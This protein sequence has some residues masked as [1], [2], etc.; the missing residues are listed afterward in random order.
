MSVYENY[1][2]LVE[3]D[4]LSF[5]YNDINL[6]EINS[7]SNSFKNPIKSTSFLFNNNSGFLFNPLYNSI[8][9]SATSNVFTNDLIVHGTL[10]A[11]S[12]PSNVLILD[13]DNKIN[14]SYLPSINNFIV[15]NTNSIAIGTSTPIAQIQLNDGNAYF[16][17]SRIG[18]GTF[19]SYY[20]HL[21]KVDTM[22]LQPAFVVSSNSK[23]II[24]IYSEL[25]TIVINND[26]SSLDTNAKLN[27]I[28]L[29][30]TSEIKTPFFST[31]N[32]S[33]IINNELFI[34]NINS[35]QSSIIINSNIDLILSN[36]SIGSLS[37]N[38][39][40]LNNS[41]KYLNNNSNL[42]LTSSNTFIN[43]LQTSTI[44]TS[45]INIINM[46]NLTSNPSAESV[47]D[48]KGKIRLFNDTENIIIKI[49]A[50]DTNI[51]LITKNNKLYSYSSNEISLISSNFF[52]NTFKAKYN[53][54]AYTYNNNLYLNGNLILQNTIIRD[55]AIS[56]LNYIFYLDNSGAVISTNTQSIINNFINLRKIE[57]YLDNSYIVLTNDY[58][59]YHYY[60]NNY[61]PITIENNLII[62]DFASGDDHT[63]VQTNQGLWSFGANTNNLTFKK[64]YSTTNNSYSIAQKINYFNQIPKI[65]SIKVIKNS[66]IVTDINSN[67]YIFG[68]INKLYQTQQIYKINDIT[69]VLDFCCDNNS[70]YLLSYFNDLFTL[71][72]NNIPFNVNLN[73]DFYGTSIKSKGSII[74]GGEYFYKNNPRNSLLVQNFIGVGTN[75]SYNSN[76]S[77]IINGNINV[78]GSI[79]NNNVLFSGGSGSGFSVWK[80]NINDIYYDGGNVGIGIVKPLTT[81][82][83]NGNATFESNII[84]KGKIITDEISP[85]IIKNPKNIYFNGKFDVNSLELNDGI[86]NINSILPS[87]NILYNDIFQQSL[88]TTS[89]NT[90]YYNPIIINENSSIIVNSYFTL[91]NI[92]NNNNNSNVVI[93]KLIN[94]NWIKY[95]ITDITNNDTSFGQSFTISKDGSNIFIGAYKEKL[96]SGTQTGGIYK[97]SFNNNNLIK[98]PNRI[99]SINQNTT[100]NIIGNKI[101]CSSDGNIL[102]STIFNN[103]YKIFIKNFQENN[104]KILDFISFNSFHSSFNSIIPNQIF[105]DTNNDGSIIIINFIFDTT[106]LDISTFTY[107]NFYIIKDY[108]I[109]FL[110]FNSIYQNSF[111]TS[112]SI[113]SDNTKIFISTSLGHHFIYEINFQN[114]KTTNLNSNTIIKYFDLQPSYYFYK[115]GYKGILSKNGNFFHLSNNFSILIFKYNSIFN[116]W[117]ERPLLNLPLNIHNYSLSIDENG[118]NMSISIIKKI[119]D[120]NLI[121]DIEI[122]NY[123]YSIHKNKSVFNYNSSN[124]IVNT[125][126]YFNS[127]VYCQNLVADGSNIYNVQTNN[128]VNNYNQNG[129]MYSSN[130]LIHSTSNIIYNNELNQ[131]NFHTEP[132]FSSNI[133]IL[134]N[135]SSKSNISTTF[136]DI[137]SGKGI[138]STSNITSH[139]NIIAFSNISTIYGN[140]KSASNIS[141]V[142]NIT[143]NNN[144]IGGNRISCIFDIMTIYGNIKSGNNLL[145]DKDIIATNHIS[146]INGNI[147]GGLNLYITSNIFANK[148]IYGCLFFGDGSNLSN[149]NPSNIISPIQIN[150]GGTGRDFFNHGE[151]LIGNG[152]DYINSYN[153][154]TLDYQTK[155]LNVSNINIASNL[156]LNGSNFSNLNFSF[157]QIT[158]INT[159]DKGGLGF[160]KISKSNLIYANENNQLKETSNL[161]WDNINSNFKIN[162]NIIVNKI[163]GDGQ[164]ISNLRVDFE[165]IGGLVPFQ[166]GGL[167]FNQISK[168][169]FIYAI[170]DNLISETSNIKWDTSNLFVD[171]NIHAP[172][173]YGDGYNLSNIKVNFETIGGIIPFNKGGLGF[174][175][176][177]KSNLIFA[178]DDNQLKET[179]NLRWDEINSNFFIDG[180]IYGDGSNISNINPSNLISPIQIDKGGTGRDFFSN[181]EILFGSGSNFINSINDFYI[182]FETKTLNVSNIN[183]SSNLILNG[184]N[185]SNLN[186]SFEQIN[187]IIGF[188]KGGLG[189]NQ[190]SKSNLIFANENNQLLETSNLRWDEINSNFFIDG[191]IYGDGSNISNINYSNITGIINLEKGGLGFNQISKSNLIFANENNQLKETSNLRWDEINS[192]F[193]IDGYI[194]GDGS[195]ISNINYSNITGIIN[196]EKGGLGFNQISKS[197]L[198]FAN[199]N[200]QLKETSNIRWDEINSNFF[201]DG[202]IYGDGSNISNINYSNIT[203]II[204]LEKGGLG[205]NQISKSNL[206]YANENNQL[207]ETSNICWDDVNSNLLLDGFLNIGFKNFDKDY[208]IKVDGNIYVSGNVIGLSDLNMKKNIEII[209]NPLDKIEKLRGV[210]FNYKN[211][212]DRRQIGMIAQEVENIIPEVVYMT[213]DDTKAIAYNNLIGLLIEG[214]KELS[215][216]I[217]SK[218]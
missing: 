54:Y 152:S 138:I 4:N 217:K 78:I 33:T 151:I 191:Y 47:M 127:S 210:Y 28:G 146:A 149:I 114:Y 39:I 86:F 84:I 59:I 41:V 85:L 98:D 96:Q 181:G 188:E 131:I 153:D 214:I 3:N 148:D 53:N 106:L 206:I 107:F 46:D 37:S 139:S 196:L 208:K 199:E 187:G 77:M 83:I 7:N 45:N 10:K 91:D 2:I 61:L 171:G 108:E 103:N 195:N 123:L 154:F 119:N 177:S 112:L 164:N 198:I 180:Y 160:N 58:K 50:N 125:E 169:N 145:C 143:A 67:I 136:G 56:P 174:N 115:Y 71:G 101:N 129:M 117:D 150:K 13:N 94:N 147:N 144:I 122:N 141:A 105:I 38:I 97:Y 93:Y 157:E 30:K 27:V 19:P 76:Y 51:F 82:H 192:N 75:I 170:E 80:K 31:S 36:N 120:T 23:H 168:S 57:C 173:F 190:I 167:G 70:V 140:I 88:V 186:F 113:S 156:I 32:N 18:I 34:N 55:F 118:F 16:N 90:S 11:S 132:I 215:Y 197:N 35:F 201:I 126:V 130:N 212:D 110:K 128:L 9:Y 64:G 8:T 25:G 12:F 116:T 175:Q 111:I 166:K 163:Y 133:Y 213:N 43:N 72:T 158:G 216:L 185:F 63:I 200:N 6:L 179:S 69:N 137:I 165:T 142:N 52:Y 73:Q 124:I 121:D 203:G 60:N 99:L 21:N 79:F 104:E 100:Y 74:I 183:I 62:E 184:A 134:S 17:N 159:F 20:F 209:E 182:D 205:F 44:T 89:Y 155:T 189:F 24:D 92:N 81:L 26:G 40:N 193:F 162:G 172:F 161:C 202:Y 178:N 15:Y 42:I 176:I 87:S 218:Y 109:F 65:T 204:S 211:N 68:N 95:Q 194:Y 22:P 29:F 48:F 207:K 1:K 135:I 49:F 66:S 14:S 102:I 5:N